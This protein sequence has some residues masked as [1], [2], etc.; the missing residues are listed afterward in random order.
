[1]AK[2]TPV[3]SSCDVVIL[4]LVSELHLDPLVLHETI[5]LGKDCGIS[6][7]SR[8][9]LQVVGGSNKEKQNNHRVEHNRL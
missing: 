7:W 6:M 8:K 2:L 9:A 3:I 1:M 4:E 5:A